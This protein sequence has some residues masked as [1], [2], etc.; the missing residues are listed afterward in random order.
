MNI[1]HS[2]NAWRDEEY[3][4]GLDANIQTELLEN[5]IGEIDLSDLELADVDGGQNPESATPILSVISAF[6]AISISVASNWCVSIA[7]GGTC[8]QN[9][10]GCC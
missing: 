1:E 5:P 9:T 4:D 3:R 8:Q 7:D 10:S 2:V 6:T